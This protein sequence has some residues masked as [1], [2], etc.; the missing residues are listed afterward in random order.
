M[1][2]VT[3][4]LR[5]E[6]SFRRFYAVKRLHPHLREDEEFL[7][8]FIEEARLAGLI[9]HPNVVAV[10]D[11]DVDDEGPYLLMDFVDGV[12]L[13]RI[14]KLLAASGTRMPVQIALRIAIDI[15]NGLHCAH[16]LSDA[17]GRP[18]EL[19][20]RD[21]SL[22]N[23]LVGFDGQVR[24]TD[25]GVAKALGR[26]TR[27]ATGLLK[28]KSGYMSPEQLRYEEPDRR[29]DLFALG[30]V[31]YEMLAGERLY[32]DR[33][34]R[35]A[36]KRILVEPPPD[37]GE[38]RTDVPPAVVDLI[39]ALL[40]KSPDERPA[41]AADVARSLSAALGELARDDDRLD[42]GAFV[43]D[44]ARHVRAERAAAIERGVAE[45][46]ETK[47]SILAPASR[48]RS[49]RRGWVA[50]AAALA[51]VLVL[52]AAGTAA[53]GYRTNEEVARPV[54]NHPSTPAPS[55]AAARPTPVAAVASPEPAPDPA[56]APAATPSATRS[57]AS[58]RSAVRQRSA[59][60]ARRATREH[61][62]ET[63]TEPST[64]AE[65]SAPPAASPTRPPGGLGAWEWGQR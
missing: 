42:V 59:R 54:A 13:G 56:P 50:V 64:S 19:V 5:S 55:R 30:I 17:N 49:R 53:L 18:L 31:L 16:E 58:E 24:I 52:V 22:S 40:A 44:V 36:A 41:S 27:T 43:S 20:H 21:L 28:G 10:Q 2:T 3:L 8:M 15:A 12:D 34:D 7:A 57:A 47:S 61:A 29:S 48:A 9:H 38:L 39:F 32:R 35:T 25:F 4:C 33:D 6:G 11:V 62:V 1:G 23:V 45:V 63:D 14:G 51:L 65:H 46:S 60:A 37:I 26:S